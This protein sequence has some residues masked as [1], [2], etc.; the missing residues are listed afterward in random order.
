MS[1]LNAHIEAERALVAVDTHIGNPGDRPR[2]GSKLLALPHAPAVVAARGEVALFGSVFHNLHANALEDVDWMASAMPCILQELHGQRCRADLSRRYPFQ[3][4]EVALVGWS[5]MGKR[6]RGVRWECWPGES[7]FRETPIDPWSMSPNP[8]YSELPP[9]PNSADRMQA[10]ARDQLTALRQAN[11]V[12]G[13]RLLL[14]EVRPDAV[15]VRSLCDL[16]QPDLG[17]ANA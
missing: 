8:G 11:A 1:I 4:L 15:S 12:A 10:V 2:H 5:P 14:A 3:G 6:M 7:T 16:E 9:P 17:A 13:G